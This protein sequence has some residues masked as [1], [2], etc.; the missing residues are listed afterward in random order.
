MCEGNVIGTTRNSS[1]AALAKHRCRL[2]GDGG[3]L[4]HRC[5]LDHPAVG[6]DH[7]TRFD[8]DEVA[9][10]ELAPYAHNQDARHGGTRDH[11]RTGECREHHKAEKPTGRQALHRA[12][13]AV[14]PEG[15]GL[16][17]VIAQLATHTARGLPGCLVAPLETCSNRAVCRSTTP[18]D[19]WAAV[20]QLEWSRRLPRALDPHRASPT[21]GT[22]Q[23]RRHPNRQSLTGGHRLL[24][25]LRV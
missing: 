3:L 6:R 11:N 5:A 19:T 20:A 7:A 21:D 1:G 14:L 13:P 23:A 24:P 17:S 12:P 15:P 8:H 16:T 9:A 25:A 18:T 10:E 4:H 22:A 2:A